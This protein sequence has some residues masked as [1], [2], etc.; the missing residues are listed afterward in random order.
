MIDEGVTVK[1]CV[2]CADS[3]AVSQALHSHGIEVKGMGREL[4]DIL[5]SE[6]K[7]VTF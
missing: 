5:K 1:A 7:T 4:S 2:A 6:W 3:Y